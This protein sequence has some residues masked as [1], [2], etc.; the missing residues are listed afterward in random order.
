[1]FLL[2]FTFYPTEERSTKSEV[3]AGATRGRKR[4]SVVEA[5]TKSVKSVTEV[6]AVEAMIVITIASLESVDETAVVRGVFLE[7]E[8]SVLLIAETIENTE[9]AAPVPE[10]IDTIAEET[11][12][13]VEVVVATTTVDLPHHAKI[14][15]L[16]SGISVPFFACNLPLGCGNGTLRTSS[17]RLV[18]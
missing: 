2:I 1:M 3:A 16:R 6:V 10:T 5:K 8:E 11:M 7:N 14:C 13:V 17:A 15:L 12:V 9:G 4:A 18:V